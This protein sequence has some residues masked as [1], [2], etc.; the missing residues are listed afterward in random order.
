[1]LPSEAIEEFKEIWKKCFPDIE[2]NDED[3]VRRANNLLDLYN[4]VYKPVKKE[5]LEEL[6]K[7]DKSDLTSE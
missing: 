7:K 3:A 5:W 6:E 2:L 4:A 1:M